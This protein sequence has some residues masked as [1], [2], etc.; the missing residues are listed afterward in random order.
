MRVGVLLCAVAGHRW[1][2]DETAAEVEP[3]ICCD[4]CGA[5]QLA[6]DGTPFGRRLDAET[7]ADRALGPFGGRR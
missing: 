5:R 6:P 3:V 2:V 7:R 1:R 4:R